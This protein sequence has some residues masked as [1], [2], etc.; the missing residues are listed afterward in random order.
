MLAGIKH[1]SRLE[2]VMLA[3]ELNEYETI[4]DLLVIDVKKRIIETSH[5]N[6]VLIKNNQLFTPK[7]NKSGV[8]GVAL[9]W[10]KAH[11]KV[12]TQ[13]IKV[14]SLKNYDAMMVCNSIRGFRLVD[15]IEPGRKQCISF[16][17]R[18][19]IHDKISSQWD[20]LFKS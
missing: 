20:A 14:Q 3:S 10:L 2:Q 1:L 6:L 4:D 17:T 16:G 19:D 7:L 13:H 5:Q 15:A 12:Q 9:Q 8:K 18:H 11:H